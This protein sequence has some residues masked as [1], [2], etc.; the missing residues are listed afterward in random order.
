MVCST[1]DRTRKKEIPEHARIVTDALDKI[2]GLIMGADNVH[3]TRHD[4]DQRPKGVLISKTGHV[5][6]WRNIKLVV[7]YDGTGYCGFQ[8]QKNLPTIQAELEIAIETITKT[9]SHVTASGRTDAGVHALG[10]VVNFRTHARIPVDKFV[11]ALNSVLP[12]DIR[13]RSAEEVPWRFHAR[14]DACWKTYAYSIDTRPVPSVFIRNFAYHLSVPL[15][16]EEMKTAAESLVGVHDF[17]SF[18]SSGGSVKTFTRNVRRLEITTR[19]DPILRILIEADGFLYNMARTI[20]G[21]LLEVGQGKIRATDVSR[22]RDAR[23]RRLAGPRAPACGLCLIKVDYDES[24]F[25]C[26]DD[27]L[28]T[29]VLLY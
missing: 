24:H 2:G 29:A 7:E 6:A 3:A 28:D 9:Y 20:V 10:Q 11:P 4:S 19:D 5:N 27:H 17:S 16:L 23:D 25:R 15:N 1:A 14:Y 26:N 8:R 22:I 12:K 21:T 13:V 18:A